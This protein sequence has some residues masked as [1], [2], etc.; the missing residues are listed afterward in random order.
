MK[1][2]LIHVLLWA[3]TRSQNFLGD[4]VFLQFFL[5]IQILFFKTHKSFHTKR[6][7]KD[8]FAVCI[9]W[10]PKFTLLVVVVA[11]KMQ[12]YAA[13]VIRMKHPHCPTPLKRSSCFLFLPPNRPCRNPPVFF[14]I[15][16]NLLFTPIR[17]GEQE[18]MLQK[19]VWRVLCPPPPCSWQKGYKWWNLI[20]G[21]TTSSCKYKGGY[22]QWAT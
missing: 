17:S 5:F 13:R 19:A 4:S 16:R 9:T 7:Y 15:K 14:E 3:T 6:W 11:L 2:L 22:K 20:S 1:C 21:T 12:I 10:H 8:N 18:K